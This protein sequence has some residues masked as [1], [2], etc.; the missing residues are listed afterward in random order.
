MADQ[1]DPSDWASILLCTLNVVS[2]VDGTPAGVNVST[3]GTLYVLD[4]VPLANH[5]RILEWLE[6]NKNSCMSLVTPGTRDPS[7]LADTFLIL[8]MLTRP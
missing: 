8:S 2:A 7:F 3:D 1:F 4:L 5:H 6:K